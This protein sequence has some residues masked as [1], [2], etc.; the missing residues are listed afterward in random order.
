[1]NLLPLKWVFTYK[2]DQEGYL[3]KYKA[4]ICVREDCQPISLQETYAATLAFRVFRV[5]MALTVVFG[6]SAE[7]LDTVNAFLNADLDKEVFCCFP[8]GFKGDPNSCL[9]L[10]QALYG[11]RRSPLLWLQ[12]LTAALLD[13]GLWNI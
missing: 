1:T 13:L 10:L 5:L 7:Q 3:T 11:L 9:R 12:E 6:L 4:R 2:F 8:E